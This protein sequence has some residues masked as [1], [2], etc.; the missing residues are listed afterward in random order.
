MVHIALDIV[1]LVPGIG[2]FADLA[3]GIIYTIEGD[4]VNAT[5]SF[6]ATVPLA[7]WTAVGIKY[8]KKGID[9]TSN[10]RTTLHWVVKSGNIIT[11]GNR[12]QLRKVLNLAT[13]DARQ[14]HHIIPWGTST[15][16]AIQKAASNANAFH[17]NEA[18]NGIPLNTSVHLGSHGNY[19]NL[20]RQR[21]DDIPENAT[22]DEAYE[23]VLEII[24]DVRSAISANPNTH[25]NNLVF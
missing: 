8:A 24:D 23:Q 5:L 11:F 22:P 7:G 10:T 14:A 1:G 19:D 16:P 20:I 3:N 18:L 13:G 6:A 2:E 15:H 9:I 12:G 17:M 4:G 25:I 21:L